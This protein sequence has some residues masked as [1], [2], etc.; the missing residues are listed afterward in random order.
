MEASDGPWTDSAHVCWGGWGVT[1]QG[2][3]GLGIRILRLGLPCQPLPTSKRSAWHAVGSFTKKSNSQGCTEA[4]YSCRWGNSTQSLADLHKGTSATARGSWKE[5]AGL[6]T[7]W[8]PKRSVS[9]DDI[10]SYLP[11]AKTQSHFQLHDW[12]ETWRSPP[13]SS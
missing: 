10:P 6:Q 7:V 12:L 1:L 9:E 11:S 5:E 4:D 2:G 3:S 13:K 8:A